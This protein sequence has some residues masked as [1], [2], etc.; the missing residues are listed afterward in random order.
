MIMIINKSKDKKIKA[1]LSRY[2]L[3]IETNIYF[4]PYQSLRHDLEREIEEKSSFKDV[5][6]IW[7][8]STQEHG[9]SLRTDNQICPI[10]GIPLK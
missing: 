3:K 6:M 2:M 7:K 4:W 1:I 10:F 5:T 9:F 8:D